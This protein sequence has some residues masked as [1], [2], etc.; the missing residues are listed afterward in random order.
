MFPDPSNHFDK[1]SVMITDRN[2][3]QNYGYTQIVI[4]QDYHLKYLINKEFENGNCAGALIKRVQ[5][6]RL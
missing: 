1:H 2:D 5:H 6:T 4:T 3:A